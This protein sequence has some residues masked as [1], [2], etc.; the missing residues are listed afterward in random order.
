LNNIITVHFDM[1][2]NMVVTVVRPVTLDLSKDNDIKG[3]ELVGT[4]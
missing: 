4:L 1:L 3:L 2:D